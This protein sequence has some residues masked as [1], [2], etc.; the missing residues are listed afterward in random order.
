MATKKENEII[1][2]RPM[3]IQRVNIRIVGDTPLIVHKWSEKAKK[4]ILDKQMKATKTKAR[5]VRDPYKEFI[6]SM[7]WIQG[8]PKDATPEDFELAV[9]N[10]AKW[11]F[12]ANAIKQAGNSAAYR[13]KWVQNQMQLRSTYFITS[14]FGELAEI[15]G[16][17]PE[18]REDSVKI[19]MGTSDLR[20]RAEFKN[21]YMDLM[22][23][24]NAGGDLTLEQI[25]NVINLGG[26]ACGLGEWRI[27]K[28]GINGRYHVETI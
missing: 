5:D 2:I 10:G 25:I 16:C 17:I 24:F 20:Y 15:K 7:Y 4:E 6:D 26:Y 11:G 28:D 3:E 13:M 18:M 23:E 1:Q 14:E 21:W 22:L 12:P 19:G 8:E 9:Q 27:E